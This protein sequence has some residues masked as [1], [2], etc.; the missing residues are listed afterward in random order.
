M[1]NLPQSKVVTLS[2]SLLATGSESWLQSLLVMRKSKVKILLQS[3]WNIKFIF[4][5]RSCK[6]LLNFCVKL[7]PDNKNVLN[8]AKQDSSHLTFSKASVCS[9]TPCGLWG[10]QLCTFALSSFSRKYLS[11]FQKREKHCCS[12]NV[13]QFSLL[14]TDYCKCAHFCVRQ[15]TWSCRRSYGG[16]HT[17]QSVSGV[18]RISRWQLGFGRKFEGAGKIWQNDVVLCHLIKEIFCN[19]PYRTSHLQNRSFWESAKD[20]S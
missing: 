19:W 10:F 6:R 17:A 14:S 15:P 18:K 11:P 9:A 7:K 4:H 3:C 8:L 13:F 2:L 12:H 1:Q 16:G 5:V 20:T